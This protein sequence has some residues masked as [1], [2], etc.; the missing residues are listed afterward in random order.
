MSLCDENTVVNVKKYFLYKIN[1]TQ[2]EIKYSESTLNSLGKISLQ[3]RNSASAIANLHC[4]KSLS[5]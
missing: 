4:K 3:T 1:Y 2:S 5:L